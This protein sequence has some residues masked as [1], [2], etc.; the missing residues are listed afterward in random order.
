MR[1]TVLV[2]PQGAT[3]FDEQD[4]VRVDTFDR[5]SWEPR[6]NRREI[7]LFKIHVER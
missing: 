6:L 4:L 1:G 3:V 5:L 2:D 7:D